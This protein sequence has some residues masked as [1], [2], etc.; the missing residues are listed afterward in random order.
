MDSKSQH[1]ETSDETGEDE[2]G[3]CGHAAERKQVDY[4]FWDYRHGQHSRKRGD[5]GTAGDMPRNSTGEQ[6][7]SRQKR[8]ET[9]MLFNNAP[10]SG[11][12]PDPGRAA[13]RVRRAG[14]P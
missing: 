8:S 12:R 10:R 7:L 11:V 9:R 6:T 4:P 14:D 2:P 1:A 13:A 3:C 5:L